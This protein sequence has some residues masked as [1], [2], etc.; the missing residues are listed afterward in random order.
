MDCIC[1]VQH[2]CHMLNKIAVNVAMAIFFDFSEQENARMYKDVS[3]LTKCLFSN[4]DYIC[5]V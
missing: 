2:I 4:M 1:F 3:V 5:F